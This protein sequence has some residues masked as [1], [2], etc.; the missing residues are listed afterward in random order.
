MTSIEHNAAASLEENPLVAGL[1]DAVAAMPVTEPLRLVCVTDLAARQ[2]L[3]QV[4][5]R[6]GQTASPD[7]L[8]KTLSS[9]WKKATGVP[10]PEHLRLWLRDLSW[11]RS[12][13]DPA[14]LAVL[15]Q[16]EPCHA[17]LLELMAFICATLRGSG[18]N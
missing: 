7:N 3:S 9:R 1:I 6:L 8:A 11:A 10:L 2:I 4:L 12:D 18:V 17:H 13:Q 14:A 15:G 5:W 16:R